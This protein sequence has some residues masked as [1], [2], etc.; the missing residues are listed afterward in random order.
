[1][2][3]KV[4]QGTIDA[5]RSLLADFNHMNVDQVHSI[6][7]RERDSNTDDGKIVH[8]VPIGGVLGVAITPEGEWPKD[9][10]FVLELPTRARV[11]GC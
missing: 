8:L 9:E 2:N 3:Y 10:D 4:P 11:Q 6:Q 7:L 5:A 1:M